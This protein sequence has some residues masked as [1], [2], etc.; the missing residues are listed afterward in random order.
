MNEICDI[1]VLSVN[2]LDGFISHHLQ[3]CD[4]PVNTVK[5]GQVTK[6][7]E[8]L[9]SGSEGKVY[10]GK[11]DSSISASIKV[12]TIVLGAGAVTVF[13]I[14]LLSWLFGKSG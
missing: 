6:R 9:E 2:L 11:D 3:I 12:V 13:G 8:L 4:V 1:L 14:P 7:T 10:S 5:A